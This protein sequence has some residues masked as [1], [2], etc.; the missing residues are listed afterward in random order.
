MDKANGD[1]EHNTRQDVSDDE[2][3]ASS[4]HVPSASGH[5]QCVPSQ[6][7][8]N[9]SSSRQVS[10]KKRKLNASVADETSEE[11]AVAENGHE[12]VKQCSAP[13]AEREDDIDHFMKSMAAT[14]RKLPPHAIA[15]VKYEIHGIVHQAEILYV[16][17][18]DS[19]FGAGSV[20]GF[21]AKSDA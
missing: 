21:R 7:T 5:S 16:F 8:A 18:N 2:T 3:A 4:Q 10:P 9:A 20:Y 14:I 19:A 12:V 11:E 15:N 13:A 1:C 17:S 6:S